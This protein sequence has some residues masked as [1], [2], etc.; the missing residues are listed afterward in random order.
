MYFLFAMI[1]YQRIAFAAPNKQM[2]NLNILLQI[3]ILSSFSQ[4]AF[5]NKRDRVVVVGTTTGPNFKRIE[6]I[7][8]SLLEKLTLLLHN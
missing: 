4:L 7:R 1:K 2:Y 3:V 6:G 5:S 8:K